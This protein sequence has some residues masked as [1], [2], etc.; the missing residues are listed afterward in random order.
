M[1]ELHN[2]QKVVT[3]QTLVD[4]PELCVQAGQAA[5]LVGPAGSGTEAILSLLT[6]Q[7]QPTLGV[8]LVCGS[9][10]GSD[11]EAFGLNAGVLFN[12]DGLYERQTARDNLAFYSRLYG[13]DPRRADQVLRQVGLADQ[14]GESVTK[15]SGSLKRRLAFG[16]VILH[17]PKVLILSDPFARCD[18]TSI[19]LLLKLIQDAVDAGTAVL[20]LSDDTTH[21]DKFCDAV[22]KLEKGRIIESYH[23]QDT[24]QDSIPFKIPVRLDG[25]VVLVN[26][27]EILFADASDGK[28]TLSTPEG[29]LPTPFTLSELE[30]RLHR[31]GFFRAHRSYL[32]NLQHVKEVI[33]YTRN[34]F[35]LRLDDPQET[36]IPLSKTA[37]G[38]LKELLGF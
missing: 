28:A 6:G 9:N 14:G 29:R 7:T 11:R 20:V 8:V 21:L 18:S 13:V 24:D 1:I 34:S 3:N 19:E 31:R 36:V 25:K 22:H 30:T 26:P 32:V 27:V 10:P 37:A 2:L 15:L 4:I 17:K 23:P 12:E 35:S 33:P 16:R 5:A 38:E